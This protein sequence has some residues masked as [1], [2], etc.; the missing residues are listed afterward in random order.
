MFIAKK[1]VQTELTLHKSMKKNAQKLKE[2][3]DM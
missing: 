3:I 1:T 2:D